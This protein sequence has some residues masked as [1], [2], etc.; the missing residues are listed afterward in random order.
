MKVYYIYE[1]LRFSSH[2][3]PLSTVL[4]YFRLA[5]FGTEINL[6]LHQV[7]SGMGTVNWNH[8]HIT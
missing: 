4:S 8:V 2:A 5:Q 6:W 3:C 7:G 1:P